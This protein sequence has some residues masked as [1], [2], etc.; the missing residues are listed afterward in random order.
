MTDKEIN[1]NLLTDT[2]IYKELYKLGLSKKEAA[3]YVASLQLGT[4]TI[5]NIATVA[6]V[7]RATT[8][9]LIEAL[10]KRGLM[11]SVTYGKKS[12]F[13]AEEPDKLDF[14]IHEDKVKL[15]KKEAL[16][17]SIIPELEK[18]FDIN[19]LENKTKVKFYDNAERGP[20]IIS[21]DILKTTDGNELYTF[22]NYD[23]I[24]PELNFDFAKD[25]VKKRIRRDIITFSN[26]VSEKGKSVLSKNKKLIKDSKSVV[27]FIDNEDLLKNYKIFLASIGKK[28]IIVSLESEFMGIIINS[29]PVA[30][31]VKDLINMMNDI[32]KSSK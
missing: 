24:P 32:Q 31:A 18:I 17:K 20:D 28:S 29:K 19:K 8:Y 3:V 25:L 13:T 4:S 9:V 23:L 15:E 2:R 1:P 12:F 21:T 5:Q 22:Y 14:F 26:F 30:L 6:A 27:N 11:H 10:V 7:N 16:I